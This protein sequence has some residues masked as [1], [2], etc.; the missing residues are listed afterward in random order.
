MTPKCR[1][2][3]FSIG[4]CVKCGTPV[5]GDHSRLQPNRTCDHCIEK[6]QAA[7]AERQ[8]HLSAEQTKRDRERAQRE[9]EVE[10]GLLEQR[11]RLHAGAV[12]RNREQHGPEE[13]VLV[14]VRGLE[15]RR[16]QLLEQEVWTPTGGVLAAMVGTGVLIAMILGGLIT[17]PILGLDKDSIDKSVPTVLWSGAVLGALVWAAFWL[18]AG[19]A[20][21][22]VARIANDIRNEEPK[23]GCGACEL[24]RSRR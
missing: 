4:E 7:E 11:M 15:R 5:C 16:N 20:R 9:E 6:E 24:C 17:G 19:A 22:A 21:N 23:L 8:A 3:T 14:R 10:R 2:G 1:C 12:A 13:P 18:R